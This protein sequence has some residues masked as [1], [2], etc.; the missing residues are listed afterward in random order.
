[1]WMVIHIYIMTFTLRSS[2]ICCHLL[3]VLGCALV[4]RTVLS[5]R[6]LLDGSEHEC[7]HIVCDVCDV[8]N[9]ELVLLVGDGMVETVVSH[10]IV[11]RLMLQCSL[12]CVPH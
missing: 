1:M 7:G 12:R 2:F 9:E 10:D 4:A 5:V 8:D 11:G 6:A 3:L